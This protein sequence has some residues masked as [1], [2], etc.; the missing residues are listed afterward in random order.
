MKKY[1]IVCLMAVLLLLGCSKPPLHNTRVLDKQYEPANSF[2]TLMPILIGKTTILMPYTIYDDEDFVLNVMGYTKDG[3]RKCR[4]LYVTRDTF[5]EVQIG[6]NVDRLTMN[7]TDEHRK[8]K[9]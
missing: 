2:T 4:R 9:Q 1:I 5:D 7:Y 8:E 3:D 6:D